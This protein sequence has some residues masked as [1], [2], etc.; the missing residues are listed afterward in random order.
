E[1]RPGLADAIDPE[2]GIKIFSLYGKTMRPTPQMLRGIDAL[3]FDIQDIGTRFYTYITTM[4][5]A[6]EEAAKAK[7]PYYVLDRPNPITGVR[8]EGPLLD[9][10][11]L[12]FVGYHPIPLRHGMTMGEM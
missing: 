2:T 7:I 9:A 5:Y 1:D 12:S 11:K 3:V 4:A 6:M 8:V 10:D